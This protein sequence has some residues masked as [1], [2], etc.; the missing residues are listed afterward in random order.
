MN[1][2]LK[3]VLTAGVLTVISIGALWF[4]QRLLMPK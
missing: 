2:T 4:T 3:T 1:K